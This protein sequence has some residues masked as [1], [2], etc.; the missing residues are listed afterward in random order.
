MEK[1][2]TSS[3]QQTSALRAELASAEEQWFE[4]AEELKTQ[5]KNANGVISKYKSD[6][7]AKEKQRMAAVNANKVTGQQLLA[8]Q[9]E[10]AEVQ[11]QLEEGYVE[12]AQT[13]QQ[14]ESQT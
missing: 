3:D 11:Y 6:I 9:R 12:F 8:L 10:R 7:E 5:L 14:N 13:K 4:E 1:L 2:S